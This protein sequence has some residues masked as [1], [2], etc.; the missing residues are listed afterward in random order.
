[1]K[2]LRVLIIAALGAALSGC[3]SS[4]SSSSDEPLAPP[5]GQPGAEIRVLHASSDAPDVD[6]Y[7]N[8][9][10]A[11]EGLAFGEATAFTRVPAQQLSIAI[12][13]AGSPD[14][15]EPVYQETVTP[16]A[17]GYYTLTAYGLLAGDD[18]TAF[19]LLVT[20]DMIDTPAAGFTR[21]FLLHAAPLVGAVDVYA[22]TGETLGEPLVS[23][24]DPADTTDM[25]LEVPAGEY[26]FRITPAGDPDTVVYDSGDL[27]LD[28]GLNYFVAALDR[29]SGVAPASLV[30]LLDDPA[31]V[32]LE[33][34]RALVRAMH[35]APDAPAVAVLVNGADSG[36]EL[37]FTDVSD[38][39]LVQAGS[40]D[41]AV[42]LPGTLDPVGNTLTVEV[43]AGKA[44]SALAT[45]LLTPVA[46]NEAFELRALEDATQAAPGND[47]LVRVIHAA[48]DAPNVDILANGAPLTG[49]ED[50]PFFTASDYLSVPAGTYDLK[51]NVTGTATT[52]LDLPGTTLEAGS[53]YT[54]IATG[55]LPPPLTPVL[56]VD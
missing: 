23:G 10:L 56:V 30:A 31:F 32:V 17:D 1:M 24:F 20:P 39:L 35:L 9:T 18:D 26:R 43:E 2:A 52:A 51:V 4:S 48:P 7:I 42:S 33:D 22:A 53:I 38:Y 44:Y 21:V 11:I 15:S 46:A 54:V 19:D 16:A 27:T 14:D 36:V 50:V 47:V 12:R 45:G 25:Y 3:F 8:D 13:A 55:L 28:T 40:Y 6:I 5:A 29:R 49:L 37:T 34:N 41:L